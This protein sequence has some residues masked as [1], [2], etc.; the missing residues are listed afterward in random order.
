M[1]LLGV[2]DYRTFFS[3]ERGK[4]SFPLPEWNRFLNLA[5]GQKSSNMSHLTD[6]QRYTI[7]SLMELGYNYSQIA[8][9]IGKDKSVLS[10]EVKRNCDLRSSTYSANLA[11]RKCSERHKSKT[12]NHRFTST[13]IYYV[14]NQL[15]K[16][17]SPEQLVGRAKIDGVDCVSH[18]RI[19]QHIWLDKKKGGSLY[20]HLRTKGKKYRK[21][22]RIVEE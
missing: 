3:E 7:Q 6:E 2:A 9:K 10:R 18:E 13:V 1:Q 11:I 19:Y 14:N 4:N 8:A 20:K 16:D 17:Y 21:R 5:P 12:K 15:A 22:Q